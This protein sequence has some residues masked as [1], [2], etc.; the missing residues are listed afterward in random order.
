MNKRVKKKWINA[1]RSGKYKKTTGYLHT[2]LIKIKNKGKSNEKKEEIPMFCSL[3]VLCDL[4]IK[5]QNKKAGSKNI[6]WDEIDTEDNSLIFGIN[7]KGDSL[8]K[9][10]I[11]WAELEDE[12][13]SFTYLKSGDTTDIVELNDGA[14]GKSFKQIA[15]II[16]KNL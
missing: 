16:E 15:S 10:V 2:R 7:E 3:G 13:G 6:V 5:E 8:P 11:E 12:T 1:L 9:E 4:Y 14:H